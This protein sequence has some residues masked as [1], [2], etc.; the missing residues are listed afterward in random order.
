MPTSNVNRRERFLP[1]Q[2]VF[3]VDSSPDIGSGHVMRCLTLANTLCR[4]GQK[5]LFVCRNFPG[6]F[7]V[8]I[9]K[10]GYE[11]RLLSCETGPQDTEWLGVDQRT[12]AEETLAVLEGENADWVI[13]DHY[14]IDAEWEI[15]VGQNLSDAKILVIDDLANRIHDCD[16]LMDLSPGRTA[17]DYD[18]L[19]KDGTKLYIGLDYAL[20]RPEF[21]ELR[22]EIGE[23]GL[24]PDPPVEV[25]VTFGG[26][27]NPEA[28]KA[29]LEALSELG[30]AT[31]F[32]LVVIGGDK[33]LVCNCEFP[34]SVTHI[35][36][37]NDMAILIAKSDLMICAAGGT[38]WE[39]C[40]LG[41]PAV[42]L[43]V[44]ENQESNAQAIEKKGAGICVEIN[45]KAILGAIKQ[46]LNDSVFY[47][48]VARNAWELC[49][50]KGASRL[51]T[52]LLAQSMEI[53]PVTENDAQFVYDAR[54]SGG[55]ERFYKNPVKPEFEDHVAWLSKAILSDVYHLQIVKNGNVQIAHARLDVDPND[56]QRAEIGIAIAPEFRGKGLS[57]AVLT[58]TIDYNASNGIKI[59]DAEVH[60][61][62]KA[63]LKLF[64]K[65]GFTFIGNKTNKLLHY[66]LEQ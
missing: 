28:L 21:S 16:A 14:G 3:R 33:K 45:Q 50:G 55:V 60:R 59:I 13:I 18:K 17:N 61:D 64:E 40:C 26:G 66:R 5:C 58:A 31:Q 27:V 4:L 24:A 25:L 19:V 12:D 34:A 42:V 6:N 23:P 32:N 43:S 49:D 52:E 38:S 9:E 29:T 47:S 63:S 53:V 57:L 48:N 54:Y 10:A 65:A 44:A 11:V 8:R 7:A 51:A 41:I 22:K 56:V 30:K 36:F 2:F 35:D 39:R 46:L 62:N 37:T 20:L 1:L 15:F